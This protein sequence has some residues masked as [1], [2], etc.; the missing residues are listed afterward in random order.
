MAAGGKQGQVDCVNLV[1]TFS[2]IGDPRVAMSHLPEASYEASGGR[3]SVREA[4]TRC[5]EAL[6]WAASDRGAFG[7]VIASGERVVIKPNWV[8]H[9]NQGT[10]GLL[11]LITHQSVIHAV[12]DEVL[13][14]DPSSVIV[15]DAPIQMCDWDRLVGETGMD[16]WAAK[17]QSKEPRFKGLRDFRRTICE[18]KDGI[19]VAREGLRSTDDYVLFNLREESL[20]EPITKKSGEFRVTSYDPRLMAKTHSPK[21]HQYLIAREVL[22]ADVIVNVPKLK[23]H[24]KAGIS[25]ALKNLVGINGNKE[26]LPHHRIGGSENGGDCYPGRDPVKRALERLFDLRNTSTSRRVIRSIQ[27]LEKQLYRALK[28]KGDRLGVEGAWSGNETVARMTIDLNRILLYGRIDRS[29]SNTVQRRVINIVDA[30][31]AGQG[32]GPLANDELPLGMLMAGSNQVAVD[33]VGARLLGYDPTKIPLLKLAF[34][35]YRWK[36]AGFSRGD[37][38]ELN[39]DPHTELGSHPAPSPRAQHPIGWVDAA[40]HGRSS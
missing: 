1:E 9:A 4:L 16:E 29:L 35:D 11:P 18:Y 3:E 30:V 31:V 21:N 19:R 10:A 27:F 15:G 23:T 20:L 22:D 26:Y 24:R 8:L 13:K 2:E 38:V 5:C 33:L 34:G 7:N 17:M 36:I 32:D 12:A 6:G 28:I 39:A 14:A 25:C 37:V 40:M